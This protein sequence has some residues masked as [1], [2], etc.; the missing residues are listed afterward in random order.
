MSRKV[1][2]T[3]SG[4]T[5]TYIESAAGQEKAR[6]NGIK[7]VQKERQSSIDTVTTVNP[8]LYSHSFGKEY[9]KYEEVYEG[10]DKTT[11][12]ILKI[13]ESQDSSHIAVELVK[14][15]VVT[16]RF[17]YEEGR[18]CK[19]P[20]ETPYGSMLFDI[21]THSVNLKR[22]E[23]SIELCID[24]SMYIDDNLISDNNVTI[25]IQFE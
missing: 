5:K 22:L 23:D 20:Y 3:S 1:I 16:A 2:I 7:A 17:N 13:V 9:V 18:I 12:N 25:I 4:T 21:D 24:Y 8:G 6:K 10:S 14:K 15:G 11:S 19:T